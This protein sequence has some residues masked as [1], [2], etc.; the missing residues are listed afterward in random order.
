MS[1]KISKHAV[2]FVLGVM[3]IMPAA[4]ASAELKIGYVRPQFIFE[5]Y[6][7]YNEALRKIQ[8]F[9]KEEMAA[10]QK[11]GEAFQLKVEEA[12]K[13]AV[14][15]SDEM[16]MQTQQELATQK[17]ALDKAYD[18]L[19]R[20]GGILE[21]KQQEFI[22][23]IIKDINDVLMDLGENND[24]DYILDA[25]QGILFADEQFDISDLVLEELN[26]GISTQ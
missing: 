13:Q 24:Y 26:K 20:Q 2:L 19:Y 16:K 4:P 7:P 23:P 25:E 11:E 5:K 6:A 8:D 15:M 21:R 14:L 3:L 17:E 12:S 18:E 10:L 9:E 22:E 1:R